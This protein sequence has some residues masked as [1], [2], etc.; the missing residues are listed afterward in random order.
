M[1][2]SHCRWAGGRRGNVTPW[3]R[4]LDEIPSI[5]EGEI[6]WKPLQHYF[7]LTGFGANVYRAGHAGA[8][9]VGEH[10]ELAG[11]HE[12]LYVVLDGVVRFTVETETRHCHPG[13]IV[14]VRDPATRRSAVAESDGAAVL[15]IGNVPAGR[16]EST[17]DASHFAGVPTVDD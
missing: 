14:A 15:A 4:T 17:W 12:E 13:T 6:D 3:P 10:D 8:N 7:G 9:L 2:R 5:E 1:G 11:G 16:F